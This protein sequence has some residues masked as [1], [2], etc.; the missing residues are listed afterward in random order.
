[1]SDPRVLNEFKSLN[2]SLG[3]IA[4]SLDGIND[5][6]RQIND[7][8]N[9]G[10]GVENQTT[11]IGHP[12]SS[13]SSSGLE[14]ALCQFVDKL[15]KL[16]LNDHSIAIT[17]GL[18]LHASEESNSSG[19]VEPSVEP[20]AESPDEDRHAHGPEG[21]ADVATAE[22][23]E[24]LESISDSGKIDDAEPN[25][26]V[27]PLPIASPPS[28]GSEF[29]GLALVKNEFDPK[30]VAARS[31][32]IVGHGGG[33]IDVSPP[34]VSVRDGNSNNALTE[35]QIVNSKSNTD[36]VVAR[37]EGESP[38]EFFKRVIEAGLLPPSQSSPEESS[39]NIDIDSP[40]NLIEESESHH[41]E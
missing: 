7:K 9:N 4:Q 41:P 36:S 35:S 33:V 6:L 20:S 21:E 24:N 25:R 40:V 28:D 38:A 15:S 12:I 13:V 1:M 8:W 32:M 11:D 29:E 22:P 17:S 10:V 39:S 14:S 26:N 31:D 3:S 23:S 34:A 37:K 5:T 18:T 19:Q 16:I 27:H 30:F 2:Y